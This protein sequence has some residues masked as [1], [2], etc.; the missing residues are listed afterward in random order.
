[1]PGGDRTG[2]LGLGPMTGG[3]RG[4]CSG[5]GAPGYGAGFCAGRGFGRFWGGL[6]HPFRGVLGEEPPDE[7]TFLKRKIADME[8]SLAAMKE[9]LGSL[10]KDQE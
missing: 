9:R 7:A 5:A 3:R 10:G 4:W 2:P 1:M 8:G 6:C